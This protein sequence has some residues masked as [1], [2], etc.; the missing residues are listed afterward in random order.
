MSKDVNSTTAR[1]RTL[2]RLSVLM[3]IY[4]ERWTLETIVQRV[5]A[6]PVPLDVE[7]VA[8]DDGSTDGSWDELQRLA[9]TEARLTVRRHERNQGKGSAIRTAI[10]AMTGD[11]AVV[12]DADL[13]YDPNEYWRLLRPILEDRADAVFGSRYAG[14]DRQVH[15]FWHTAVNRFL[16]QTSNLLFNTT[17]SDMETC[18]KMVR[19]DVLRQLRL[20]SR[21]FTFEPELTARLVQWG[22]RI[23]EVPISYA[24][25]AFHEGKKI[26][27]IDGLKAIGELLR[28]R[29]LDTR[30][31]DNEKQLAAAKLARSR[32]FKRWLVSQLRP[33]LGQRVLQLG[34]DFAWPASEWCQRE[35]F[36]LVDDEPFRIDDLNR[37][38]GHRRGIGFEFVS[39]ESGTNIADEHLAGFDTVLFAADGSTDWRP[40]LQNAVAALPEWGRFVM[41]RPSEQDG[42]S[43]E[44]QTRD[45]L[46]RH[47]QDVD[48]ELIGVGDYGRLPGWI[49]ARLGSGQADHGRVAGQVAWM[50]R[51]SWITRW[52]DQWLATPGVMQVVI[53]RK[54]SAQQQT[55]AA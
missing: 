39:A 52:F 9:A 18:Y 48:C 16:T 44:K 25:R 12:Q 22:A 30:F 32:T 14:A 47:L 42:G 29:L 45:C 10:Q 51:L 11:V 13:E 55:R 36:Q 28:C 40:A 19:G 27:P 2:E 38:Y 6:A 37:R 21:T 46:R 33:H 43:A 31:T 26:R 15:A 54:K 50:G 24:G 17:L 8:V 1:R 20:T 7:I 35:R 23:H 34:A 49:V 3:P 4:N 5:L 41:V 53:A